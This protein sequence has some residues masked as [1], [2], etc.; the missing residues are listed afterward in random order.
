M[1][2]LLGIGSFLLVIAIIV[3][4]GYMNTHDKQMKQ[5][6]QTVEEENLDTRGLMAKTLVSLGC[7]PENIDDDSLHVKYQGENF[8]MEFG[9]RI[10]RIW[11]PMWSAIKTDDPDLPI[12]R[13]AVN[14]A[15]F[16]IGPTVVMTAPD[17][18][19]LIG[20]HSRRD[21]MLH[22]A[23]PENVPFVRSVLDSFFDM[24]QEVR[25]RYQQLTMDQSDEQKKRRPVGFATDVPEDN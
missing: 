11:D 23:C 15:N 12:L 22:P 7:Q 9:G 14:A 20:L 5:E 24:K 19:G 25:K 18:E 10:A 17:E 21:I 8:H 13:E 6:E 2:T 1:E 3:F 16:S 4:S